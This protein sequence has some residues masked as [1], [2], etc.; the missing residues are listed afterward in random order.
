MDT[1]NTP[2]DVMSEIRQQLVMLR[3][4]VDTLAA[5]NKQK[6]AEIERLNQMLL[7]MQRA[8]FGQT[9]E[10]R[11][12]VLGDNTEQMTLFESAP[13]DAAEVSQDESAP[14][15]VGTQVPVAGHTRKKKRTLEE[16]C[17]SLPVEEHIVDLPDE[18]KLTRD[19][20]RLICIGQEYV[21]T[22]LVLERAKAKVVKHYRKVY[23]DRELE[24]E[25]GCT[26]IGGVPSFV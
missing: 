17:A 4:T 18:E 13:A 24:D 3:E 7:N 23:A 12:Y 26:D 25:T 14:Q 22:E 19:G 6:D 9:S 16:M 5:Q 20:T 8:R 11:S 2:E 10:K 1:T 15:S 21:R